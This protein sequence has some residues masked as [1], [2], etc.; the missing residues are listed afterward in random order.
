M[1]EPDDADR[2]PVERM[3]V[4]V[5]LAVEDRLGLCSLVHAQIVADRHCRP[6]APAAGRTPASGLGPR[7]R[8]PGEVLDEPFGGQRGNAFERSGFLEQVA[9]RRHDVDAMRAGQL[10]GSHS[11]ELEDDGIT[12]TDDQQ[13]R[14]LDVRLAYVAGEIGPTASRHDGTD[15]PRCSRRGDQRRCRTSARAEQPDAARGPQSFRFDPVHR[16]DEPRRRAGRCRTSALRCGRPVAPR[17]RSASPRAGSRAGG[18]ADV[19][20]PVGCAGCGDCSPTRARTR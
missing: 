20:Q 10:A 17:R 15:A 7:G 16:C 14:R 9:C 11:V 12:L 2:L 3:A 19:R 1:P 18:P 6:A 5:S 13:G 4:A 8:R